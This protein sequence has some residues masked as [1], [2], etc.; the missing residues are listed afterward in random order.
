M[1]LYPEWFDK[2]G[3]IVQ[4]DGDGGDSAQRLGFYYTAAFLH[5]PNGSRY[6]DNRWKL[7]R[8]LD[9]IEVKPGTYIRNPVRWN[10]PG[11]F[12]R[13]QQTPLVIAMGFFKMDRRL[14]RMA[15]EHLKR[16]GKY[17]N[18]DYASPEHWGFYIRSLRLWYLYPLLIMGDMF[19]LLNTLILCLFK[20]RDPDNVGDD[21]NH[22]L[23][24][25]QSHFIMPTPVSF[26]AKRLYEDFRP[27][28]NGN[29]I[30]GQ[31]GAIN[32]ALSWYFR[33]ST[34]APPLDAVWR[35]LIDKVFHG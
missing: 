7:M 19:T 5:H 12:S 11:D 27:Y 28:N 35:P 17:Q 29:A 20:G 3:L 8:A 14:F 15:K 6:Q 33:P 25:V 34:N 10:D 9:T 1:E 30:L 32:G 16:F 4:S 21:L 22:I 13:D 23:S 24:L 31:P 18:G 2:Y 26:I